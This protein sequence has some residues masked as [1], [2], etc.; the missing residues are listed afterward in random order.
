MRVLSC[1]KADLEVGK[2][3]GRGKDR[4]DMM[5]LVMKGGGK[6]KA[7]G[8]G[9]VLINLYSVALCAFVIKSVAHI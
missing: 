9:S 3:G 8:M 1:G 6:W 7:H 5:L 4:Q 2:A